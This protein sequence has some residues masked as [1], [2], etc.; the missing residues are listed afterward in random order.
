MGN[1]NTP[2]DLIIRSLTINA[3]PQDFTCICIGSVIFYPIVI[4]KKSDLPQ[5]TYVA[6]TLEKQLILNKM[7][8]WD[9]TVSALNEQGIK[10]P[11]IG[12]INQQMDF[13]KD[14]KLL[15]I[16]FVDDPNHDLLEPGWYMVCG[17]L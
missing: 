16:N 6:S 13:V 1:L 11:N 5:G 14:G 10:F 15:P 12:E 7:E 8:S 4:S 3:Q 17:E 2:M 9:D